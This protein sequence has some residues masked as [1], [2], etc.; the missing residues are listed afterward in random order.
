[1]SS[2]MRSGRHPRHHPHS[3]QYSTGSLFQIGLRENPHV[4]R[5]E[6]DPYIF[7]NARTLSLRRK[8]SQLIGPL[9]A[10]EVIRYL[11]KGAS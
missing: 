3:G 8:M 2:G 4:F 7:K 5:S 10:P 11:I 6:R 9:L 1:M